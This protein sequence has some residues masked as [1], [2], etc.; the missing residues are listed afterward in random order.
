M[1]SDKKTIKKILKRSECVIRDFNKNN[2]IS[3][4]INGNAM[5]GHLETRCNAKYWG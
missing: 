4:E 5:E 1:T 3:V 2:T